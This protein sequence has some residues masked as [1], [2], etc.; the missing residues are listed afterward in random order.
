V[1]AF[2]TV[3]GSDALSLIERNGVDQVL[4]L[5]RM[6]GVGVKVRQVVVDRQAMSFIP[7]AKV[8]AIREGMSSQ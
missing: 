2:D 3:H 7:G 4:R 6:P 1:K 8:Q 5:S